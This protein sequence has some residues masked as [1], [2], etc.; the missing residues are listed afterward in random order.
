MFAGPH[1]NVAV[2]SP[3]IACTLLDPHCPLPEDITGEQGQ[4][5][6]QVLIIPVNDGRGGTSDQF[7]RAGTGAHWSLMAIRRAT[8][9]HPASATH[10]DSLMGTHTSLAQQLRD[11]IISHT[12]WRHVPELWTL[13]VEQQPEATDSC[14]EFLVAFARCAM[15]EW[16]Q[17]TDW[18]CP[19]LEQR[20]LE[21]H[22][23]CLLSGHSN[24]AK[25]LACLRA[26]CRSVLHATKN[27]VFRLARALPFGIQAPLWG[28]NG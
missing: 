16:L 22:R 9:H 23:S 27:Y 1:A 25:K 12:D 18:Q 15:H 14:G 13:P 17:G 8:E 21:L 5:P 28:R 3:A 2:L 11:R 26:L 4:A 6:P 20:D 10:W 24:V 19:D 7:L